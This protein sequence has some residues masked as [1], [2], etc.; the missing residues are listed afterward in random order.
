MSVNGIIG[1][2]PDFMAG[3]DLNNLLRGKNGK[4]LTEEGGLAALAVNAGLMAQ[5]GSAAVVGAG[6]EPLDWTAQKAL[7]SSSAQSG[8][9]NNNMFD[10]EAEESKYLEAQKTSFTQLREAKN[11]SVAAIFAAVDMYG[12]ATGTIRE[13]KKT[14]TQLESTEKNLEEIKE[15][16][17]TQAAEATAPKD[18][19]GNPIQT[20]TGEGQP[21]ATPA[22]PVVKVPTVSA[23][24]VASA[25]AST[26]AAAA[27]VSS[28][29]LSTAT[30]PV[31][32][33]A[34]IDIIV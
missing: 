17:E 19:D 33:S 7:N 12:G 15:S 10:L 5:S 28:A 26:A 20:L 1:G 31:P 29:P 34:S 27:P 11:S 23:A 22:T 9:L 32:T 25:T 2:L 24:E 21:D 8:M 3:F 6:S 30:A 13:L 18:A 14:Q 16:I 4:D